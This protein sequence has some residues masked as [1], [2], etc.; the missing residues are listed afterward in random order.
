MA[1]ITEEKHIH[2]H[3]AE[4]EMRKALQ[5]AIHGKV[6]MC[7]PP[8]DEDTDIVLYDMF[9][10]LLDLRRGLYVIESAESLLVPEE[11]LAKEQ[12]RL[13]QLKESSE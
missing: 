1:R 3:R 2:K 5:E 11:M 6:R 12:E 9:H 13:A 7:I 8:D 10:E 4:Q